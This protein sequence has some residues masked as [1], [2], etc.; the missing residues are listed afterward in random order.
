MVLKNGDRSDRI[1]GCYSRRWIRGLQPG[2]GGSTGSSKMGGND[3]SGEDA[4][5]FRF[6]IGPGV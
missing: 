4:Y 1:W 2:D 3:M 5:T 6:S